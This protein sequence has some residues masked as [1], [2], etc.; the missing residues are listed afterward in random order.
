MWSLN[1]SF[2]IKIW[3]KMLSK[4]YMPRISKLHD[5]TF[6][7][8]LLDTAVLRS[9]SAACGVVYLL[10]KGQL[11]CHGETTWMTWDISSLY[12][13]F[14]IWFGSA[15]LY[16]RWLGP[17]VIAYKARDEL[18]Q[19]PLCN[20]SPHKF[21][22]QWVFFRSKYTRSSHNPIF[23]TGE[24]GVSA[25]RQQWKKTTLEKRHAEKVHST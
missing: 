24:K 6:F 18:A 22:F 2:D 4:W 1:D 10:K 11:S 23:G 20:T 7:P 9:L 15:G 5:L 19:I 3:V 25:K 17:K 8:Y 16:C 21:I 14:K 12:C 13:T